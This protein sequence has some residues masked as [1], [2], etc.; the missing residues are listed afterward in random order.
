MECGTI[1]DQLGFYIDGTLD[2]LSAEKV[3]KHLAECGECRA[4]LASLRVLIEA[5]REIEAEEPPLG[6]RAR[7]AAATTQSSA[8]KA[9]RPGV[10]LRL[11]EALSPRS[12]ALAGGLAC[13]IAAIGAFVTL[14]QP[15][16]PTAEV[17]VKTLSPAPVPS[18]IHGV[19]A[20]QI[21]VA[22]TPVAPQSLRRVASA[23]PAGM[24]SVAR[25]SGNVRPSAAAAPKPRTQSAEDQKRDA[26]AQ[27]VAD[28]PVAIDDT[29]VAVTVTYKPAEQP[30]AEAAK[31]SA[32]KQHAALA[33]LASSPALDRSQTEEWLKEMKT[34]AAMRGRD[35]G[36]SLVSVISAKF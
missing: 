30:A 20:K 36:S 10:M 24:R 17:A 5:A 14:R 11:R 25:I 7:I 18:D 35:R 13:A 23:K 34:K 4:E 9:Y 8:T 1:S 29:T 26:I 16:E 28:E 32:S 22:V 33:K 15:G 31:A 6:L 2:R 19:P 21:S 12:L 3:E 27:S